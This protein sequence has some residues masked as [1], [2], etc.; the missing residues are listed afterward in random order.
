M[1]IDEIRLG[2]KLSQQPR[3]TAVPSLLH[4][5][6]DGNMHARRVA[7]TALRRLEAWDDPAVHACFVQALEDPA[8]WVRYDAAWGLGESRTKDP[9]ALAALA[10]LAEGALD[11]PPLSDGDE[12]AKKQAKDSLAQLSSGP[13]LH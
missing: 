10:K 3:K 7:V 8:G 2:F 1:P 12:R 11:N 6:T 4:L 13:T 9:Q 5:A